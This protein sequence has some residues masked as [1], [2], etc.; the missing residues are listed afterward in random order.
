[1]NTFRLLDG[2]S[3]VTERQL[4]ARR[5]MASRAHVPSLDVVLTLAQLPEQRLHHLHPRPLR[6]RSC[7][8]A[9]I[10]AALAVAA[11]VASAR[12]GGVV[13]DGTLANV[14]ADGALC[15]A[16][17][18]ECLRLDANE[19]TNRSC[20]VQ[21]SNALASRDYCTM[22][23]VEYLSDPHSGGGS[24]FATLANFDESELACDSAAVCKRAF[25]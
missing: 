9:A 19:F 20:T 3:E 6:P 10:A 2:E 16:C 7:V 25:R 18:D 12:T 24:T 17:N 15:G 11:C 13:G 23:G 5:A 22:D 4:F 8:R 1:M 14:A 21:S